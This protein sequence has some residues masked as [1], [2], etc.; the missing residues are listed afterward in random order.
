MLNNRIKSREGFSITQ[1]T[2]ELDEAEKEI[3]ETAGIAHTDAIKV[4]RE[5]R[6]K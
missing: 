3:K 1:Y 4:I 2:K 5:W 6:K